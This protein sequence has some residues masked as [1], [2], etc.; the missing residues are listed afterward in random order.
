MKLVGGKYKGLIL[1]YLGGGAQRTRDL[2]GKL[3]GISPKVLTEQL[4]QLEADGLVERKVF[5]EVPPRVEYRLSAEGRTFLPALYTLCDWGKGAGAANKRFAAVFLVK[6]HAY[7][8][9]NTRK[10]SN[11]AALFSLQAQIF[12][13]K[14]VS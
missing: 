8:V 5:A 14:T 11:L 2:L 13:Q 3:A 7:R 1:Y 4:R 10:V 6:I 12:P 9:K